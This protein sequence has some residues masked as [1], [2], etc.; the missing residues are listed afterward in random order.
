MMKF[1]VSFLICPLLA[2][3]LGMLLPWWSVA[4][5]GALTGFFIP[6]HRL[7]SFL[8]TFLGVLIFVGALIFFISDANNHILAQKIGLL[9]LKDKNE[10]LIIGVSALIAATVAGISAITGRSLAIVIKRS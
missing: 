10:L 3:A 4:I 8:S 5:A 7:L 2:Y 1:I 9:V 6:Q